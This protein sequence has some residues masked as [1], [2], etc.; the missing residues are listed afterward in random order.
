M[1]EVTTAEHA[2]ALMQTIHRRLRWIAWLVPLAL[3]VMV[4]VDGLSRTDI[5]VVAFV[6]VILWIFV[7]LAGFAADALTRKGSPQD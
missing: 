7:F 2:A 4:S 3:L 5:G 1:R 6:G